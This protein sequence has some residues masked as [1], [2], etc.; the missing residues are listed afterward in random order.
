[1][2]V[3]LFDNE[4]F[5]VRILFYRSC[6]EDAVKVLSRFGLAECQCTVATT[7]E[8]T[9]F[10]LRADRYLDLEFDLF[11]LGVQLN[12]AGGQRL[13]TEI[14]RYE[15]LAVIYLQQDEMDLPVYFGE[16]V[17]ICQPG[18]LDLCLRESL[19]DIRAGKKAV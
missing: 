18:D 8:E 6:R 10:W 16:K 5:M 3:L 17:V 9:I 13:M 11:L 1:M 19:S 12:P 7:V 14:S 15:S 4:V 2:F